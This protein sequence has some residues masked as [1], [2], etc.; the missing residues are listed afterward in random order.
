MMLFLSRKGSLSL[1]L[2]STFIV[3]SHDAKPAGLYCHGRRMRQFFLGD[4]D[5]TPAEGKITQEADCESPRMEVVR[6]KEHRLVQTS[7]NPTYI[8]RIDLA[9]LVSASGD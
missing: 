8:Y 1:A 6:L 5:P 9:D 2:A 3:E 7:K 4:A